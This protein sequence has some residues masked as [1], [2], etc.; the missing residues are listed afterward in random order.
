MIQAQLDVTVVMP[1]FNEADLLATSIAD[2]VKGL[3]GLDHTF[4]VIVIENGSTDGTLA[5]ARELADEYPEVRVEH[6][7]EA[8]YGA[9][10]REGLLSAHGD[11]V[12]NFDTDFYDLAFLEGAVTMVSAPDGPA[13]VVASKRAPGSHDRRPWPRRAVTAVFSTILHIVFGST[14]SDTHGM[15]V[16][17]R[18][19]VEPFARASKFGRDLFDTELM[20]RAERAGL[21]T[22]ELPVVVRE[23]RPA[24]TS[25]FRRVPRTIVGL[26]RL[27]ITLRVTNR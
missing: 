12:V 4:E 26:A 7:A 25:I 23:M 20:L 10:L 22:A 11:V 2:V 16:M 14:I 13:I 6:L 9:A 17:R 5:I 21:R 15:K 27:A 24:R 19:D 1:A 18:R 3:R 8:D